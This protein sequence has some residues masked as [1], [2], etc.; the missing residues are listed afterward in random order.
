MWVKDREQIIIVDSKEQRAWIL[1]GAEGAVWDWG[2]LGYGYERLIQMLALL[3][4]I[5]KAKAAR[6][7]QQILSVWQARGFIEVVGENRN[8]ELND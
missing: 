5:D 1:Q 8:D 2:M 3:W 4:G 7:L 6:N